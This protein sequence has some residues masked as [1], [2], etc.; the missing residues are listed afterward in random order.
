MFSSGLAQ[1]FHRPWWTQ[2]FPGY[3][4]MFTNTE[5]FKYLFAKGALLQDFEEAH[6]QG[7]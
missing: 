4:V 2:S 7:L 3:G 1:N 6:R 5:G